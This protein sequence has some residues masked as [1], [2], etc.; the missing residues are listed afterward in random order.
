MW[1]GE[2]L[3]RI[4]FIKTKKL[5]HPGHGFRELSQSVF[6]FYKSRQG[7]G[8]GVALSQ[9]TLNLQLFALTGICS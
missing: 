1:V 7:V 8:Q 9:K 3:G 2:D 6:E 4:C 5:G